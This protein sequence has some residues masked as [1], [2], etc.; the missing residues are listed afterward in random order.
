MAVIR[1][2]NAEFNK[3]YSGELNTLGSGIALEFNRSQFKQINQI[4]LS[5]IVTATGGF[6]NGANDVF[7]K[8]EIVRGRV[9]T[10][11]A[12]SPPIPQP[13]PVSPPIG[14]ETDGRVIEYGFKNISLGD[15]PH[16][17]FNPPLLFDTDELVTVYINNGYDAAA[18]TR[19]N[20]IVA[21]SVLGKFIPKTNAML[22]KEAYLNPTIL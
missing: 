11:L 2:E 16:I 13:P 17:T 22:T 5:G 10:F 8:Y 15:D 1:E 12:T 21:V 6:K 9:D 7:V 3:A 20:V 14:E 18:G 4:C 19:T